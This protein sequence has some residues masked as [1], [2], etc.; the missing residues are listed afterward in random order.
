MISRSSVSGALLALL[1]AASA[2]G[3]AVPEEDVGE[4]GAAALSER[5]TRAL[6]ALS[7]LVNGDESALAE[8]GPAATLRTKSIGNWSM[9]TR[10]ADGGRI[11]GYLL[12][13]ESKRSAFVVDLADADLDDGLLAEIAGVQMTGGNEDLEA[14]QKA[15]LE[16]LDA[17]FSNE[18]PAPES[19][20]KTQSLAFG[21]A[22]AS[23]ASL[24][25]SVFRSMSKAP[26]K[27]ATVNVKTAA[28]VARSEGPEASQLLAGAAK[29]EHQAVAASAKV[30]ASSWPN[31]FEAGG[32]LRRALG[33]NAF[34]LG[35]DVLKIARAKPPAQTIALDIGP[36]GVPIPVGGVSPDGPRIATRIQSYLADLSAT[37]KAQG[38]ITSS[39]DPK[40]LNVLDI[41]PI[42]TEPVEV[43]REFARS[44]GASHVFFE[45]EA[46]LARRTTQ[47]IAENRPS[48]PFKERA[49]GYF[50]Y[51]GRMASDRIAAVGDDLRVGNLWS[52]GRYA[53]TNPA[54][55]LVADHASMFFI[56]KDI[57]AFASPDILVDRV[58]RLVSAG[59]RVVIVDGGEATGNGTLGSIL[60]HPRFQAL[61]DAD[62][63]LVDAI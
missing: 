30:K 43:G 16:E 6:G 10:L 12:V 35:D 27:A 36:S 39:T 38:K 57:R 13:A 31:L 29:G 55:N 33:R 37:Q 7:K 11:E 5:G 60:R 20:A 51:L 40:D 53:G 42:T 58:I 19:E 48:L 63:A 17:A 28:A 34:V 41:S 4:D 24:V 22:P 3:C 49:G 14:T 25:T 32:P 46:E 59:K 8:Y 54:G 62:R 45:S 18:V 26:V 15:L 61:S 56:R 52:A 23:F 47:I 1:V 21:L 50:Y 44:T 9:L 2:V